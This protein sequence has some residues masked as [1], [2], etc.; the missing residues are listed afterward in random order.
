MSIVIK[1]SN[2][3]R[4]V[5]LQTK[6]FKRDKSSKTWTRLSNRIDNNNP[7]TD[8]NT[9]QIEI[10]IN[11]LGDKKIPVQDFVTLISPYTADGG[12]ALRSVFDED[13]REFRQKME[14]CYEIA[15]QKALGDKQIA[16]IPL[17]S[18]KHD[19][20]TDKMVRIINK[21]LQMVPDFDFDKYWRYGSDYLKS[22]V[23][24]P[25]LEED[26]NLRR[27]RNDCERLTEENRRLELILDKLKMEQKLEQIFAD[28][29]HASVESVRVQL[30]KEEAELRQ[31]LHQLNEKMERYLMGNENIANCR[32]GQYNFKLCSSR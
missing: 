22:A 2:P 9:K 25:R 29:V 32:N 13:A 30:E 10:V 5:K 23:P 6:K 8:T 17:Y 15:V 7:I 3:A 31:Q 11:D 16:S 4:P 28:E 24:V 1:K 21:V 26:E 27:L 12:A 14:K 20:V 19:V 18:N